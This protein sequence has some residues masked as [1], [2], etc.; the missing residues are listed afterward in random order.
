MVEGRTCDGLPSSSTSMTT[1]IL[2]FPKQGRYS[3]HASMHAAP[4]NHGNLPIPALATAVA[5]IAQSLGRDGDAAS[6]W[7]QH[8]LGRSIT[9]DAASPWMQ[10]HLGRSITLDAAAPWMQQHLGRSSTLA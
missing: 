5:A 8:H 10:H 2:H 1:D 4:C 7:T 6:P 9:L 3:D